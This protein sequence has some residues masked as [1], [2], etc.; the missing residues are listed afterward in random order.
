MDDF[1]YI[2]YSMDEFFMSSYFGLHK[3]VDVSIRRSPRIYRNI[4]LI[5]LSCVLRMKEAYRMS[6]LHIE[7]SNK[8]RLN[9]GRSS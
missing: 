4:Y 9:T 1:C 2:E 5:A 3:V 8:L 6:E 7:Q